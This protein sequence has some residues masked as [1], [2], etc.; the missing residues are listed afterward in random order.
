MLLLTTASVATTAGSVPTSRT[1][2]AAAT[3][4]GVLATTIIVFF[5]RTGIF[6]MSLSAVMR[7]G[8]M[9]EDE[10]SISLDGAE[11]KVESDSMATFLAKLASSRVNIDLA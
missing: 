11:I 1:A 6:M 3:L 10:S 7:F 4:A 8:S 9:E 5:I 2:T